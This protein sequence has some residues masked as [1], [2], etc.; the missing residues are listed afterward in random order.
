[1]SLKILIIYIEEVN[2]Y[3]TIYLVCDN[4]KLTKI[5]EGVM[6]MAYLVYQ[7]KINRHFSKVTCLQNVTWGGI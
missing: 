2:S 1:M 7:G 4:I 3:C 5:R 6:N